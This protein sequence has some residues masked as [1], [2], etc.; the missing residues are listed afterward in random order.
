MYCML[1]DYFTDNRFKPIN[2]EILAQKW[3]DPSYEI[4]EAAQSLLKNE[5]KRIGP[6]GRSALVKYWEP[7]LSNLLKECEDGTNLLHVSLNTST[8]TAANGTAITN[9]NASQ[10]AQ[11]SSQSVLTLPSSPAIST[12][13][14]PLNANYSSTQLPL[15][16]ASEITTATS[17]SQAATTTAV[18]VSHPTALVQTQNNGLIVSESTT[19]IKRKQYIAIIIL[20]VMGAEFGQD[21]STSKSQA[22]YKTIPQGFSIEDHTII[23]RIS[24]RKL[25][26]YDDKKLLKNK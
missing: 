20:G 11:L 2:M 14:N 26:S 13:V 3:M 7:H 15:T 22:P 4:R 18:N 10:Q 9:V 21:V 24:K 19:R 25:V 17:T 1:A 6:N 12:T 16:T 5:L 23:K 8:S